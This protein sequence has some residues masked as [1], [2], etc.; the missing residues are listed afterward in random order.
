MQAGRDLYRYRRS[1]ATFRASSWDLPAFADAM[2]GIIATL[3]GGVRPAIREAYFTYEHKDAPHVERLEGFFEAEALLARLKNLDASVIRLHQI[4]LTIDAPARIESGRPLGIGLGITVTLEPRPA[5]LTVRSSVDASR[6]EALVEPLAA[7]IGLGRPAAAIQSGSSTAGGETRLEE[8]WPMKY[9]LAPVILA[10]LSL[11]SW[12]AVR[13]WRTDYDLEI[14]APA[15]ENTEYSMTPGDLEITWFLKPNDTLFARRDRDAPAR[16]E[17]LQN[18]RIVARAHGR[19]RAE[20][21]LGPGTYVIV[22]R[23]EGEADPARLTVKV[24]P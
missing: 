1:A 18:G 12:E 11:A 8:R 23:P 20:I 17:V 21:P 14:S 22:I 15:P 5:T 10:I 13:A 19:S 24:A 3:A 2:A 6:L 7:A 4:V 9:I 16:L